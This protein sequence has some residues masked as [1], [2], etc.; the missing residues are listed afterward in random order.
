M[1]L[2]KKNDLVWDKAVQ[3][4][5]TVESL[6]KNVTSAE[7]VARTIQK[8]KHGDRGLSELVEIKVV[9]KFRCSCANEPLMMSI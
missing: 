5:L 7:M 2:I 4:M 9:F 3:I 6:Q 8:A 1:E